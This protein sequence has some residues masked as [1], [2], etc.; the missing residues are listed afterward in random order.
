M[1]LFKKVLRSLRNGTF[2]SKIKIRIIFKQVGKFKKNNKEKEYLIKL[3]KVNLG[4]VMDLDNPKTFNE[5]LNWYKLNYKNDLMVKC[6]DKVLVDEYVKNKNLG[7][8]LTKKYAIWNNPDEIDISTLPDKF[9]IKTNHDSGGV[10]ICKTKEDFNRKKMKFIEKHFKKDSCGVYLEAP[11]KLVEKKIF[12]EEFIETDDGHAPNDYKIFCFNGEP[13][14]LFVGTERDIDVKF[15]FFDTKWNWLDL[16]QGHENSKNRPVKP[17]NFEEMLEIAKV[18]S[19]D[20]PHVRVDLY[21]ENGKIRFGELT[22]YHFAALT[23]FDPIEFDYK[24]G[25]YFDIKNIGVKND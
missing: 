3:G 9:V 19:K 16:R 20:F 6:V 15:D 11:Y 5:K 25:E 2:I 22:F 21:N 4:Y 12:A 13:K 14:F 7:H 24:F 17:N 1:S 10:V 8:I 23:P 18:L